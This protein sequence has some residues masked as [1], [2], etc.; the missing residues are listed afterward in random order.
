MPSSH[1]PSS[2]HNHDWFADMTTLPRT[3]TPTITKPSRATELSSWLD[4]TF[5]HGIQLALHASCLTQ[6]LIEPWS[7]IN[8]YNSYRSTVYYQPQSFEEPTEVAIMDFINKLASSAGDNNNNNGGGNNSG[9]NQYN[10]NNN[11][12]Q[13]NDDQYSNNQRNDNQYGNSGNNNNNNQRNDNQ[14]GNSGSSSNNN[15]NNN[16]RN[17][18]Q[19]SNNQRNDNSGGSS[20]QSGA[21]GFLGGL[22]DKVNSSQNNNNNNNNQSNNNSGGSNNQS[23][24][25]GSF[26]DG[27]K[28]KVNSAAG[29]G[30]DSEKNEDMLDKGI[31]FVQEKFMGQGKQDNESAIEQAKDGQIADFIRGQYKSATGSGFPVKDN[32][33]SFN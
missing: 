31:D 22:M 9:N 11:N 12:N 14:Y 6:P 33:N 27:L 17:D 10:N 32:K 16:Q 24:G 26:L 1:G 15:N 25:G 20:S 28:D 18:D 21:G 19:Y 29:G 2:T 30:R 3:R 13:R 5:L 8:Y 23:S 4:R 7:Y